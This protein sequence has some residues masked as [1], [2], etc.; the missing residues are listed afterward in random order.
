[1][2]TI[3]T[4]DKKM[5]PG[6]FETNILGTKHLSAAEHSSLQTFPRP[7]FLGNMVPQIM[8]SDYGDH[9]Q[10]QDCMVMD[11]TSQNKTPNNFIPTAHAHR[12]RERPLSTT[13]LRRSL[14]P[15]VAHFRQI[16]QESP[17]YDFIPFDLTKQMAS[18]PRGCF[19]RS[20]SFDHIDVNTICSI[21]GN[22][23]AANGQSATCDP[24]VQ[25]QSEPEDLSMKKTKLTSVVS[26]EEENAGTSAT[27]DNSM[28]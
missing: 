9:F 21:H 8:I 25:V 5:C 27:Q 24:F 11:L 23:K 10:S 13:H 12:Q 14:S 15:E 6:N 16:K 19:M 18:K 20:R 26:S 17:P 7:E 4:I 2:K 1:M 22:G 3:I 28:D